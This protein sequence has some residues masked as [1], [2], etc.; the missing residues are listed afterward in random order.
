MK[1][2]DKV[3]KPFY[4]GR[5]ARAFVIIGCLAIS[6][7]SVF[8]AVHP[9]NGEAELA[10]AIADRQ[11][12][13]PVSCISLTTARSSRIIDGTAILYDAGGTLYV[14]RPRAGAGSLDQDDILV[15]RTSGSQLCSLDIVDLVDRTSRFPSGFVS[16]DKF[17]PY[18]RLRMQVRRQ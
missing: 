6:S 14:N 4:S 2:S 7:E 18:T 13:R 5:I 15:T 11:A 1:A 17:V 10:K 16:L 8:A 3:Y 12:G 9:H